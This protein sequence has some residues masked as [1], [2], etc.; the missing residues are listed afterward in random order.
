M[1][2]TINKVEPLPEYIVNGEFSKK[3]E[4]VEIEE[5]FK[6]ISGKFALVC[7]TKDDIDQ[8]ESAFS[9]SDIDTLR[10]DG[11]KIEKPNKDGL[12][13]PAFDWNGQYLF[14]PKNVKMEIREDGDYF[15]VK[16]YV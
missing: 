15:V 16:C 3:L 5:R 6:H 9:E 14:V 4:V 10:W 12:S 2:E 11:S 13:D 1:K 8:M 7:G